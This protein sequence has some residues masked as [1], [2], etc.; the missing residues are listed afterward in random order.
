MD[1]KQKCSWLWKTTSTIIKAVAKKRNSV[2]IECRWCGA[3]IPQKSIQTKRYCNQVCYR[4][5]VR[6]RNKKARDPKECVECGKSFIPKK[7]NHL[8]CSRSCAD[9][10]RRRYLKEKYKTIN[11]TKERKVCVWCGQLFEQ[12]HHTHKFCNTFCEKRNEERRFKKFSIKAEPIKR[13]INSTDISS[14]KFAAEIEAYKAAGGK[15]T[16]YPH[17]V[18]RKTPNVGVGVRK[19]KAESIK[20][21]PDI[22]PIENITTNGETYEL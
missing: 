13:S 19:G 11:K 5:F 15:V 3:S 17:I 7:H 22:E 12:K 10:Y 14:S 8:R 6:S 9:K 2:S 20:D 1:R 16:V 21:L 4:K 18:E